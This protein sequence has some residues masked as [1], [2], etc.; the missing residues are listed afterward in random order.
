MGVVEQIVEVTTL[1]RARPEGQRGRRSHD[2]AALVVDEEKRWARVTDR[3]QRVR[4]GSMTHAKGAV[5]PAPRSGLPRGGILH[6]G[7]IGRSDPLC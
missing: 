3:R 5:G 1:G 4:R 7:T 2:D 6:V